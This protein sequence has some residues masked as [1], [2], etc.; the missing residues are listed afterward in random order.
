MTGVAERE[1][2]TKQGTKNIWTNYYLPK[3]KKLQSHR[4]RSTTNPIEKAHTKNKT[5]PN[6]DA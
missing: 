2:G 5:H 3:L 4:P 6:Q 1:E